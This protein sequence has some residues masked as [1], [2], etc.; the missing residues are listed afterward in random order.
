MHSFV[1]DVSG[2]RSNHCNYIYYTGKVAIIILWKKVNKF[3]V[4]CFVIGDFLGA[5]VVV[6]QNNEIGIR[7]AKI[8]RVFYY[9]R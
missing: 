1:L 8:R 7:T 6:A 9:F 2:S 5:R 4:M 3:F